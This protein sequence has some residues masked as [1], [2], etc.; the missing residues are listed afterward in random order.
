MSDSYGQKD[1]TPIC[2]EYQN[3]V[4][5]FATYITALSYILVFIN[6]GLKKVCIILVNWIGYPT[7]TE[8]LGRASSVIFYLQVFNA[9]ILP[10]LINANL[11]EQPFSFGLTGGKLGDFN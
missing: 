9:A 6:K 3:K 11:S 10:V 8:R 4:D 1:G 2:F 5:T 7:E